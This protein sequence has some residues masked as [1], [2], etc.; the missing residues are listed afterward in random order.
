MLRAPMAGTHLPF[1]WDPLLLLAHQWGWD[2]GKVTTLCEALNLQKAP[3]SN[4]WIQLMSSIQDIWP[5]TYWPSITEEADDADTHYVVVGT[6]EGY[7]MLTNCPM[8]GWRLTLG[9]G[10]AICCDKKQLCLIKIYFLLA[11]EFSA[12]AGR[13]WPPCWCP[14]KQA[15]SI[16]APASPRAG[17]LCIRAEPLARRVIE[18]S[19]PSCSRHG[20]RWG[21][22]GAGQHCC[23]S[24]SA[25]ACGRHIWG[26]C[27]PSPY[28]AI[29]EE[30]LGLG[31]GVERAYPQGRARLEESL[32]CK[33]SEKSRR[34]KGS[35][36]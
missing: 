29:S 15:L 10:N 7:Q 31:L 3:G 1:F 32:M 25:L 8:I 26:A 6:K 20:G 35:L 13:G 12:L 17:V 21:E 34:G 2:G 30:V 23:F 24:G 33:S 19:V 16:L 27:Q 22:G 28:N 18:P 11:H 5:T 4:T 14:G 36:M 9:W